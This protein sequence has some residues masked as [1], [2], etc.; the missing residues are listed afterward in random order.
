[1]PLFDVYKRLYMIEADSV[2]DAVN[3]ASERWNLVP[4]LFMA[5]LHV[6]NKE[7]QEALAISELI[8]RAAQPTLAAWNYLCQ[9]NDIEGAVKLQSVHEHLHLAQTK[10]ALY[11]DSVDARARDDHRKIREPRQDV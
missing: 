1:M 4:E 2:T 11:T 8:K 5:M 6:E 9:N 10:L 3:I 7:T